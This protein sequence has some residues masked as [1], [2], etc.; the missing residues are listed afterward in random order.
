M[1]VWWALVLAGLLIATLA[2]V[3]YFAPVHGEQGRQGL[4]SPAEWQ[5]MA[6]PGQLSKAHAFLKRRVAATVWSGAVWRPVT[7][8]IA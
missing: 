4:T 7:M 6:N 1:K 5:R 3:T 8:E 2:L